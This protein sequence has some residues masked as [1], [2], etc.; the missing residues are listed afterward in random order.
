MSDALQSDDPT[1]LPN[2]QSCIWRDLL[3]TFEDGQWLARLVGDSWRVDRWCG[4]GLVHL[5][6]DVIR[7]RHAGLEAVLVEAIALHQ[8]DTETAM[9]D[10]NGVHCYPV[11]CGY[12]FLRTALLGTERG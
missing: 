10:E 11:S 2:N 8:G 1:R 4:D 5:A 3:L 9:G 6:H 12:R 7:G